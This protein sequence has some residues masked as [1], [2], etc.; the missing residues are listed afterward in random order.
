MSGEPLS[1]W[2]LRPATIEVLLG[3][4]SATATAVGTLELTGEETPLAACVQR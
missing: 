4:S 2:V 1:E 3:A